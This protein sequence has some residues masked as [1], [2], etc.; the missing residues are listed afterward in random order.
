MLGPALDRYDRLTARDEF[1]DHRDRLLEQSAGITTE[2][3]NE[4]FHSLLLQVLYRLTQFV[5]RSLLKAT[6]Q[7]N[8]PNAVRQHEIVSDRWQRDPASDD[9]K[10]KRSIRGDALDPDLDRRT[11]FSTDVTGYLRAGPLGRVFAIDL[12]EAVTVP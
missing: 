8:V 9:L 7:T 10:I 11:T 6:R 1:C 12:Q 4:T 3:E 2:V 5:S